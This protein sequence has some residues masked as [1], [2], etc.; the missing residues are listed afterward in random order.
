MAEPGKR[1]EEEKM[2]F[3]VM[4]P[5]VIAEKFAGACELCEGV[6]LLGVASRNRQRAEVFAR[7]HGV[8]RVYDNYEVLLADPAPL[9]CGQ[10]WMT[11]RIYPAAKVKLF[12]AISG[13]AAGPNC[14]MPTGIFWMRQR[15]SRRMASYMS[16]KPFGIRSV[17]AKQSAHRCRFERP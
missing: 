2:N 16:W 5:G 15:T 10:I 8:E 11:M 1:K 4:G 12:S 9:A 3:G 13:D 6:T 7:R 17:K 14:M